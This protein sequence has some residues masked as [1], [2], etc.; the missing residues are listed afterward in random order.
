LLL[1]LLPPRLPLPLLLLLLQL[2][3]LLWMPQA[4]KP[5]KLLQLLQVHFTYLHTTQQR[6]H[7][8]MRAGTQSS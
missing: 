8:H 3:Q 5:K 6:A 2:L 4:R 1:L 7:A